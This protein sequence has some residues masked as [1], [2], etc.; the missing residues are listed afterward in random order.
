MSLGGGV[1]M[2]AAPPPA[3][4]QLKLPHASHATITSLNERRT[5][6]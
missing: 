6:L 4:Q 1:A 5:T 2:A 3:A